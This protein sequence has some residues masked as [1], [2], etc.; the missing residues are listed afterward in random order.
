MNFNYDFF[1]NWYKTNSDYN[2]NIFDSTNSITKYYNFSSEKQRNIFQNPRKFLDLSKFLYQ[3][4]GLNEIDNIFKSST[5][6]YNRLNDVY[7]SIYDKKIYV[8]F[9]RQDLNKNSEGHTRIWGDHFTFLKDRNN[10]I[11]F[12]RTTV[13]PRTNNNNTK[14]GDNKHE[15]CLF[16]NNTIIPFI[17]NKYDIENIICLDHIKLTPICLLN[18]VFINPVEIEIIRFIITYPWDIR[19]NAYSNSIASLLLYPRFIG[20]NHLYKNKKYKIHIGKQGGKYIIV[21]K[22]KLYIK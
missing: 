8:I 12:H 5:R 21:N 3:N 2:N 18:S 9:P 20:G 10:N 14:I 16:Q 15:Y 11:N 4:Y 13:E 17:N 19:I 6:P 7:L 1:L 22:K